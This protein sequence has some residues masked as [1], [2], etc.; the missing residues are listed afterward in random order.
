MK[1][2]YDFVVIGAGPAGLMIA[3]ELSSA[4]QDVLLVDIKKDIPTINRSCCTM[5]INEPN[6]HGD[7]ATIVDNNIHFEKTGF[8][9]RYTGQW[10]KTIWSDYI[11]TTFGGEE[12]DVIAT[13]RETQS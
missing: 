6:T 13:H 9:V 2:T 10:V 12:S 11:A 1:S 8:T 5:L 7:T 3:R 4:K